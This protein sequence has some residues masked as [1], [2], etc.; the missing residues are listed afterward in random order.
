MNKLTKEELLRM[1]PRYDTGRRKGHAI[2]PGLREIDGLL[3]RYSFHQKDLD[4][5]RQEIVQLTPERILNKLR[6]ELEKI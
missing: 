1:I 6:E 2:N 3:N 4:I 5:I